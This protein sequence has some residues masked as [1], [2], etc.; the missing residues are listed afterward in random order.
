MRVERPGP[1]RGQAPR[2]TELWAWTALD[3]MTDT[4]GIM[5]ARM[6]DGSEMPMVTSVRRIAEQMQ[7]WVDAAARSAEEPRPVARLRH[8]VPAEED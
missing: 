2:I 3:P 6:R 5:S 1:A 4:E 7:P 8:F